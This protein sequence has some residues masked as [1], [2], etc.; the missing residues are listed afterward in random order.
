MGI[1]VTYTAKSDWALDPGA[2]ELL[3]TD[4]LEVPLAADPPM[5]ESL[6]EGQAA[7]YTLVTET[8]VNLDGAFIAYVDTETTTFVF[9]VALE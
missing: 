4:G 3:T 7:T 8:D 1:Q 6:A 5:P 9:V 2:W